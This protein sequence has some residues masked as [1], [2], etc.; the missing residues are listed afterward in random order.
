MGGGTCRDLHNT[1]AAQAEGDANQNRRPLVASKTQ[2]VSPDAAK[3][4]PHRL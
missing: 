4:R 3:R 1:A 2:D